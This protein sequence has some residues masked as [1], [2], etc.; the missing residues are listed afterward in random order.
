MPHELKRLSS[1]SSAEACHLLLKA[2]A[3]VTLFALSSATDLAQAA[4]L[5]SYD[6]NGNYSDTLSNGVDLVA[7]GGTISGGR[8]NFGLNQGLQLVNALAS[9]SNYAIEIKVRVEDDLTSYNKIIDFQNLST[10]QG[11]YE[12]S[13]G[14]IFYGV[15][16]ASGSVSLNTDFTLGVERTGG[17][18]NLFLNGSQ[19]FTGADVSSYG[20]PVGNILN[21][22]ED[23]N[24]T[25][26]GE[27]FVG[28]AD[29]IRIHDDASTFDTEP[30]FFT[31]SAVAPEPT[32]L[33]LLVLGMGSRAIK[34][35]KRDS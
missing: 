12:Q 11:V 4:L 32:T 24:A 19:I 25:S 17:T 33:A 26:Q 15:S 7:S 5:K 8:Y 2:L 29:F 22:F 21:F 28:S 18:V 27:S 35:R 31:P 13:G 9:T 10:D 6:F 1:N 16:G 30:E 23:D 20:I 3:I 14:I 34:R